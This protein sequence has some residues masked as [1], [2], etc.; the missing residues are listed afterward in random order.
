MR[1][2]GLTILFILLMLMGLQA[3]AQG[4]GSG[5]ITIDLNATQ[6]V[7]AL[8]TIV[9]SSATIHP[10]EVRATELIVEASQTA[11]AQGITGEQ[12][13]ISAQSVDET[14]TEFAQNITPVP[15]NIGSEEAQTDTTSSMTSTFLSL[16]LVVLVLAIMGAAYAMIASRSE[17]K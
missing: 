3:I 5:V 9:R 4:N 1:G 13:Q 11:E 15:E 2:S 10:F 8:S 12:N 17:H 14:A 16:G 6:T 7:D